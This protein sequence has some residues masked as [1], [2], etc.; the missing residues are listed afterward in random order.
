MKH[1]LKQLSPTSVS[2]V[3]VVDTETIRKAKDAAVKQLGRS[4]KVAGFR[5][6][7]VPANLI[8][9]NIDPNAL[10]SETVE[11]AINYALND[12]IA[13]ETLR[14]LDQPKLELTKF[15]PYDTLEFT[16]TIDILP[17]IKLG[18]YKKLKAKKASVKVEKTEI[19]QVLERMQRGFAEKVAVT[20]A[21]H[22]GDE[23]VIDFEGKDK[24][25][26]SI[27]GAKG[28]AYPL[29]LGSHTF[30]PGFEE[31]IVGHAAGETFDI[32][33]TFPKD[34]HADHLKNAK[35]TFTVTLTT[36]NE[37]KLPSVDDAFAKKSGPFD[38]AKELRADIERELTAQKEREAL[39][40]LKD[41]L[42]GELVEKSDVPVP[43]VLVADQLQSLER[44]LM[45]NLMYRGQTMDDYIKMQGYSDKEALTD[46]ELR[47][48]ATRR[49]QAGL[50]LAELSKAEKIEV[51]KD[52][53][54]AELAKRKEEAPKMAEQLDSPEARRDLA[55][56]VITEKTINRLVELNI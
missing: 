19:D 5:K 13:R 45:Q 28:E 51:T 7:K 43:E 12:V 21:A 23:V 25:G 11:Y 16:A 6:G 40:K 9:K 29:T 24:D 41:D 49:V 47:P 52:E 48:M 44:D 56:R 36:V 17:A 35:V 37:V 53:L 30:I 8:E 42:L 4:V 54:D 3:V 15:V 55:N 39:D 10:G 27:E 26:V 32:S 14:V 22:D 46:S 50:V 2:V 20:R 38:S 34:Y 1:T 31:K 18:S 33:V